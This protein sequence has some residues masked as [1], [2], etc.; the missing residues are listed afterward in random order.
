MHIYMRTYVYIR[1]CKYICACMC[2]CVYMC[3]Y[4]IENKYTKKE[5]GYRFNKGKYFYWLYHF[6]FPIITY[7]LKK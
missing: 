6:S 2:V 3:A 7:I 4:K 5:E 1:T